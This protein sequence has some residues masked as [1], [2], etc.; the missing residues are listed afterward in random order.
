MT[1]TSQLASVQETF[2]PGK[3]RLSELLMIPPAAPPRS[4][5]SGCCGPYRGCLQSS[6]KE[7]DH[8]H[9]CLR[10]KQ[11]GGFYL[12]LAVIGVAEALM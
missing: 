1:P 2:T 9:Q 4:P 8:F 10:K 7:E 3:R 6:P 5:T 12:H 11:M